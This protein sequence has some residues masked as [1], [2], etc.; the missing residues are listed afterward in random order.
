MRIR[1]IESKGNKREESDGEI[2]I[3]CEEGIEEGR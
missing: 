3:G 1:E 2:R